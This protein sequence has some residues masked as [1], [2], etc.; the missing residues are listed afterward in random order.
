MPLVD[1]NFNV[2]LLGNRN[3]PYDTRLST[4]DN[5]NSKTKKP[6]IP[7]RCSSLTTNHKLATANLSAQ[8]SNARNK[9]L[10]LD[11]TVR[12][13]SPPTPVIGPEKTNWTSD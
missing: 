10:T 1:T 5:Q 8:L 3:I 7:P 2:R 12:Q 6:D 13:K 4:F 11:Q 9:F